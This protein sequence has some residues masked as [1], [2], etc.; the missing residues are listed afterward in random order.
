MSHLGENPVRTEM[1]SMKGGKWF[2]SLWAPVFCWDPN[3]LPPFYRREKRKKKKASHFGIAKV[4]KKKIPQ[5]SHCC[6]LVKVLELKKDHSQGGP[7][8]KRRKWLCRLSPKLCLRKGLPLSCRTDI[9]VVMGIPWPQ[10][11]YRA[12]IGSTDGVHGPLGACHPLGN[13][14]PI[15]LLILFQCIFSFTVH[16][17][18][19]LSFLYLGIFSLLGHNVQEQW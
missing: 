11:K 1:E 8:G 7:R 17:H 3:I 4:F 13:I 16:S 15:E 19:L 18:R 6:L 14:K 9:F 5:Q 10:G 12:C 2:S